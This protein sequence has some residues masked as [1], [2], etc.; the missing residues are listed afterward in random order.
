MRRRTMMIAALLPAMI[1][2]MAAGRAYGEETMNVHASLSVDARHEKVLATFKIENRGER[3]V[4]L[5]RTIA[6][7][8][9]LT[10]RLFALREHPGGAEVPYVGPW[11]KRGPLTAADFMELAPHSA[12]THTIDITPFYEFKPGQHTYEIR[13]EGEALGDVKQIEAASALETGAVT[14][15]HTAP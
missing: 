5:P 2:A 3:R 12:H 9:G 6:S 14:F 1:A 15:S 8:D 10:G 7:A 4:W 13:Y 11:V